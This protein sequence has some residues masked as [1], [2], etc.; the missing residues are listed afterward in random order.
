M[1]PRGRR[2]D[3]RV[4]RGRQPSFRDRAPRSPGDLDARRGPV[5]VAEAARPGVV[6]SVARWAALASITPPILGAALM[7]TPLSRRA[8]YG[9]FDAWCASARRL[10]GIEVRVIDY[11]EGAYHEPP[12]LFLQLN[13]TSLSETV[14][15]S[16]VLPV[17][18]AIF[19]NLEYVALPFVGW[20]VLAQGA[21]VVVRQWPTQARRAVDRAV[22]AMQRGRSFY[23]SIEGRRSPDGAL[24]PYK[25][26]PAVLAIRAG[27]RI[28]PVIFRGAREVLPHGEWRVRPGVVTVELLPAIDARTLTYEDRDAL[29]AELRALASAHGLDGL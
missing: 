9:L 27:A 15:A 26:G 12:Y 18:G 13:Q 16:S 29:V 5:D 4:S 24:S 21:V 14:V 10:F 2:E 22:R 28:V 8:S 17:R 23:M 19:A 25:K 6:V 11:G 20:L 1:S 3:D 7:A